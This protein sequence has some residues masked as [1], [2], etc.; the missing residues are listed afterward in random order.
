M[1]FLENRVKINKKDLKDVAMTEKLF[2]FIENSPTAYHAVKS[3]EQRLISEGY[4][5]LYESECAPLTDGGKY[6]IKRYDSSIIAFRYKKDFTGFTVCAGHSDSPA[7]RVK[8][9]GETV[10]A[11]NRIMVERYGGSIFYTWLDRPLSVAGRLLVKKDGAIETVLTKPECDLLTI[12]SVC[13]HFNNRVNESATFDPKNDLLPLYSS[14]GECGEFMNTVAAAAGVKR[15]DII[16]HDLFVYNRER[17]REV[18]REGEFI[19][20]PRLDDLACV[21]AGL[22]GFLSATESSA[23]PVLAVFDNEEVGSSTKQGA[24]SSFLYDTLRRIAGD[25]VGAKLAS[26]FMVSADNAHARHPAHPELSDKEFAPILGGGVVVKYN[27][28]QQYTT[29][30]IS[31]AIFSRICEG[32]GV[33]TQTFYNRADLR[34]GSTLGSI[35]NTKVAM[36][37]VDIGLAQLAMHSANETASARDLNDMCLVMRELFS[38]AI[39]TRGTSYKVVKE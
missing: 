14:K 8:G 25:G 16:S 38:S 34:G 18:G 5:E 4:N 35:A 9:N 22:E 27:A 3:I 24:A 10:G 7:F 17:G 20:S 2:D 23:I 33:K 29:D 36:P 13:I 37:T 32:A 39:I 31:A 26:S 6:F 21:F 19:L 30:G 15:E 12:P 11:Y 28:S 1:T